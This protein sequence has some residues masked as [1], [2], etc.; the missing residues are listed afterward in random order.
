MSN[1]NNSYEIVEIPENSHKEVREL[2]MIQLK[3]I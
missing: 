1:N 2:D 3:M